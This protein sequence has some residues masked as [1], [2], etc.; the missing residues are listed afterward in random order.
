MAF[1]KFTQRG[2]RSRY[3]F[4]VVTIQ[5][6]GGMTLNAISYSDLGGPAHIVLSFDKEE[7][8]VGLE[9]SNGNESYSFP[10]RETTVTAGNQ[11]WAIATRSF[12]AFYDID[13]RV[14]RRFRLTERQGVLS[15]DLQ[16]PLTELK[17]RAKRQRISNTSEL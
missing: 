9:P 11:T 10:I 13:I 6:S 1:E 4:A 7:Q 3:G 8:L 2:G 15:L 17:P 16:D 5:A 14:T 12:C